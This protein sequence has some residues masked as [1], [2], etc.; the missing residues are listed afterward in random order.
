MERRLRTRGISTT[1]MGLVA[2][3]VLIAG[4]LWPATASAKVTLVEKVGDHQT[5]LAIYGFG[6]FEAHDGDGQSAGGGLLFKAQRIRLGFN[7][8]YGNMFSKLFL[9]FNQSWTD[10]SGGLP[11]AIKDAFVGYRWGDAAFIRLGVIKTPVGMMFCEPGWNLDIVERSGLDKNLVLER[12]FGVLLSGRLIGF[13]NNLRTD[14]TEMGMEQQGY[15]FGYDVG[16]FNPAGRS[17]A[18][19]WDK[20]LLGDAL[21]YAG[22]LSF[23]WGPQIHVEGSYGT[24]EQ[25]GGKGTQDYNVWDVGFAS[26]L[27]KQGLELK[28]E[29]VKGTNILG[30]KDF[31]QD[32]LSLTAGYM[33]A[34]QWEGVVKYYGASADNPTKGTSKL[35]NT[36]IGL[37]YYISPISGKHKDLQRHRI[38]LN[39]ILASGDTNHWTGK[40][41]YLDDGWVLQWQYKF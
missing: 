15:G 9:D 22:R 16:V 1:T 24:S 3:T 14:G 13:E 29:Y 31:E 38:M 18:V 11:K 4:L 25:A 39:Y 35:T 36:Y 26:E 23:D 19:T 8:Y 33:I 27:W 2:I 40:W 37:N 28:A 32:T 5:K 7:Y 34:K 6:Q 20:T 30:V 41:G 12:D 10:D 21:A 17:G